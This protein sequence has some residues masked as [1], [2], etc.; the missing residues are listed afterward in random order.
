MFVIRFQI[1]ENVYY[2]NV[3]IRNFVRSY[4]KRRY[5]TFDEFEAS[6]SLVIKLYIFRIFKEKL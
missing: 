1:N 6:I 2:K 5:N 3:M 4:F